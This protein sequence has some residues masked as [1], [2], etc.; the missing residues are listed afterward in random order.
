MSIK[1]KN[2]SSEISMS[3]NN[4]GMAM[5][6]LAI[7]RWINVPFQAI[8]SL[9]IIIIQIPNI[10]EGFY[11]FNF[12]LIWIP[13]VFGILYGFISFSTLLRFMQYLLNLWN[14]GKSLENPLIRKASIYQL[15]QIGFYGITIIFSIFLGSLVLVPIY[16]FYYNRPIVMI[17]ENY[18]YYPYPSFNEI[19]IAIVSLLIL[20]FIVVMKVFNILS[21]VSID[22]WAE[23][24]KFKNISDEN[25]HHL[26]AGTKL[27]KT[28]VFLKIVNNLFGSIFYNIGLAKAGQGFK[29]YSYQIVID[30][31][32]NISHLIPSPEIQRIKKN[33][34]PIINPSQFHNSIQDNIKN[35]KFIKFC[36]YCGVNRANN[37]AQYCFNCGSEYLLQIN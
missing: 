37:H 32:E 31:N 19:V 18:M 8:I 5:E 17:A 4:L 10:I 9:F 27:M 1:S 16:Q 23:R 2:K 34:E 3:M 36:S 11:Y 29:R 12:E 13:I 25:I 7:I 15:I 21:I 30:N 35:E 22:N 6:K 26:S 24:Q 20:I 14:L 33:Q 28:A